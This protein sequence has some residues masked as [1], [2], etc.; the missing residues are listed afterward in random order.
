MTKKIQYPKRYSVRKY[1]GL[2]QA[3]FLT[4]Y[5]SRR[6]R[7]EMWTIER[8]FNMFPTKKFLTQFTENDIDDYAI[9]RQR[10]G[11]SVATVEIDLNRIR[12]FWKWATQEQ[13]LVLLD[14]LHR[15]LARLRAQIPRRDRHKKTLSLDEL[16]VIYAKMDEELRRF[17]GSRFMFDVP[18]YYPISEKFEIA[19]KDAGLD[20]LYGDFVWSLP[21]LRRAMLQN[22]DTQLRDSL[23]MELK[24]NCSPLRNVQVPAFDEGTAISDFHSEGAPIYGINESELSSKWESPMCGC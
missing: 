21:D 12:H 4:L 13:K 15:I 9:S 19:A 11:R 6:F 2:Y 5:G 3:W 24:G 17:I 7:A 20:Y 18:R 10:L 22:L 14:P 8:F 1:L 23:I 16:R